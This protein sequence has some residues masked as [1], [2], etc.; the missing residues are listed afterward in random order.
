[1]FLLIF[2]YVYGCTTNVLSNHIVCVRKE[3]LK[4]INSM[5]SNVYKVS[6]SV[7]SLRR[8]HNSEVF[9]DPEL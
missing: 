3:Y 6:S 9:S 7:E 4:P 5:V 2:V 8:C 1:M